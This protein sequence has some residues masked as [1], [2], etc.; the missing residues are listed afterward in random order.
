MASI[1]TKGKTIKYFFEALVCLFYLWFFMPIVNASFDGG[2]YKLFFFLCLAVGMVGLIFLNG[3]RKSDILITLIVYYLAFFAMYAFG[4]DQIGKTIRITLI[5]FGMALIYFGILDDSGRVRISKFMLV[6]FI[7]TCI[8]SSWGVLTDNNAARTLS[9]AAADENM[10]RMFK[11]KNIGSIYI[12]Q[13]MVVIVPLL[14]ILPKKNITKIFS[15]IILVC[16]L[17]IIIG[18]S[19]TISLIVYLF[20]LAISF[21]IKNSNKKT[22]KGF[23]LAVLVMCI[24]AGCLMFGEHI[25]TW[26]GNKLL[27]NERISTRIFE[28]RDM[29]YHGASYGDVGLRSEYYTSSLQTFFDNPFG[30][31][32]YYSYSPLENGIGYHSQI[33]DDL[34]RFGVFAIVFYCFY[35]SGYYKFLKREYDKLGCG[36]V[37]LII[38]IIYFAFLT[39]NIGFRS[40]AESILMFC[41][42]PSIPNL[43]IKGKK[44]GAK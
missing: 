12:F 20:A 8:T 15:T 36:Y 7:V 4:V 39:L 37:S 27:N 3:I 16:I 5:F 35:F 28:L 6:M 26:L 25:L 10:Q 9:H 34:A 14:V 11:L 24:L 41:I 40:G 32:A 17:F 38:C 44:R 31:G 13:G 42:I 23:L 43:V 33:L 1:K 18:A 21:F 30:V 2:I 19:F 29:L 22:A